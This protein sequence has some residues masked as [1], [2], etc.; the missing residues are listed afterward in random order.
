ME[1]DEMADVSN[2]VVGLP[3]P[4]V[5]DIMAMTPEFLPAWD[6][7]NGQE[8]AIAIVDPSPSSRMLD[9][10]CVNPLTA[11]KR[12]KWGKF[13]DEK[14]LEVHTIPEQK[15]PAKL[16]D[17]EH[18]GKLGSDAVEQMAQVC[19]RRLMVIRGYATDTTRS[20]EMGCWS[21]IKRCLR[22]TCWRPGC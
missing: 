4:K 17:P 18:L 14:I 2:L 10:T 7:A 5:I 21:A 1:D 6:R 16:Q 20:C 9:S 22:S 13:W 19:F 12:L 11:N 8:L 15:R 3:P